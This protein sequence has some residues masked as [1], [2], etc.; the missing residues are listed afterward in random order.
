MIIFPNPPTS[1]P[2]VLLLQHCENTSTTS[3]LKRQI[4]VLSDSKVVSSL[5]CNALFQVCC[6]ILELRHMYT[7]LRTYIYTC[8]PRIN[9]ATRPAT[10]NKYSNISM[11]C[12]MMPP[13]YTKL[14]QNATVP[15]ITMISAFST[16]RMLITTP[17]SFSF[18]IV[19]SSRSPTTEALLIAVQV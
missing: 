6:I 4:V 10:H 12:S 5:N 11:T 14:K 16:E 18:N 2:P 17:I 9:A 19:S 1:I 7:R 13:K 8:A 3:I 15:T